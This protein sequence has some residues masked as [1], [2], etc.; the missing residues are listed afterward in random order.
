M[1]LKNKIPID[2]CIF[3]LDKGYL[4]VEFVTNFSK[5]ISFELIVKIRFEISLEFR[6]PLNGKLISFDFSTYDE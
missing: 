2:S 5:S 1:L 6:I 4:N 3:S